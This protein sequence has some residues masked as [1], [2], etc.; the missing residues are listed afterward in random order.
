MEQLTGPITSLRNHHYSLN[1]SQEEHSSHILW[2]RSLKSHRFK[3][4]NFILQNRGVTYTHILTMYDVNVSKVRCFPAIS[5]GSSRR[6]GIYCGPRVMSSH[7]K[8]APLPVGPLGLFSYNT[9]AIVGGE[10]QWVEL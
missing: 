4:S 8:A 7:S 3:I 1:Y 5:S 2:N 10:P 6:L 9:V